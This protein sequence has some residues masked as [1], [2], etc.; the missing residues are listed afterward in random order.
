MIGV[1]DMAIKIGDTVQVTTGIARIRTTGVVLDKQ[2]A[3]GRT[4]Y[5]VDWSGP[6]GSTNP[7]TKIWTT[8]VRELA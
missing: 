4:A 5:L 8:Q 3:F 2:T 1:Y 6:N 7:D